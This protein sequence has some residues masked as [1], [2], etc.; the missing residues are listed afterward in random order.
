MVNSKLKGKNGELEV[1]HLLKE[2]GFNARRGQQ[3][4]GGQDSPDV[5][6]SVEGIH[7]EVK[8]TEAFRLYDA[9]EQAEADKNE[10]EQAVVFHRK[11][12]QPW[13]VV[14]KAEDFLKVMKQTGRR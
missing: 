14:L 7:I 5:V 13:V 6:H 8:R 11:N 9:L 3:F 4:A 2:Y 10:H 1:A 12:N